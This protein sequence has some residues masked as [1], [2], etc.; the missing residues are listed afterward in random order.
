MKDTTLKQLV[1][2]RNGNPRGMVIATV[3]NNTVRFGWSYTNTKA[4]DRFNKQKAFVIA[5]GRAEK[6]WGTNVNVPQR[7][8]KVLCEMSDRSVRYYKGVPLA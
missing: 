2:D 5:T 4:G 6:G 8:G 7:V 1:R 3:I